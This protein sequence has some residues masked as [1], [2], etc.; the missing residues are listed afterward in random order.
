M[1]VRFSDLAINDQEIAMLRR[2]HVYACSLRELEPESVDGAEVG[3]ML[4]HLY[5]QGVRRETALMRMLTT[6]EAVP[7]VGSG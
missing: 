5:Q 2:V 1:R 3:K 4:F 7:G 6:G